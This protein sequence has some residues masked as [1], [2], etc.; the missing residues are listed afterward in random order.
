MSVEKYKGGIKIKVAKMETQ[1][2]AV[3]HAV[4]LSTDMAAEIQ[5]LSKGL[6]DVVA[7][8]ISACIPNMSSRGIHRG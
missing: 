2:V 4:T 8:N 1:V 5:R 7:D 3:N 6:W